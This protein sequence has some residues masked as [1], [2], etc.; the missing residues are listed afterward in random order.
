M[1]VSLQDFEDALRDLI[2]SV[3][4]S[5]MEHYARVQK[6]FSKPKEDHSSTSKAEPGEHSLDGPVL[7]AR[8][9]KGKGRAIE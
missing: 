8:R 1:L 7:K 9:D 2:P 3:S 4:Q 5:E 6:Q